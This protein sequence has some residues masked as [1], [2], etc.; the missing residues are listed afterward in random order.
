MKRI[1]CC[2][3]RTC[4][5][6]FSVMTLQLTVP[7]DAMKLQIKCL[8]F[9]PDLYGYQKYYES[10]VCTSQSSLNSFFL[11]PRRTFSKY[12][13]P[14]VLHFKPICFELILIHFYVLNSTKGEEMFMAFY[15]IAL[16]SLHQ[17]SPKVRDVKGKGPACVSFLSSVQ[18]V[19][20]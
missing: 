2:K 12:P 18:I 10:T 11:F 7:S 1:L 14:Q 3:C 9:C 17:R 8:S 6:S 19:K 15:F 20:C 4:F 5:Y 16:Y 13:H